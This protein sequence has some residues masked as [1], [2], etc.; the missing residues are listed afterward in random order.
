[1][2]VIFRVLLQM[3]VSPDHTA[4]FEAAWSQVAAGIAANPAN[5]GQALMRDCE[6]SRRYHVLSDWTDENAFRAF[7]RSDL[8]A[9]NRAELALYRE[10]V[11]MTTLYV[12]AQLPGHRNPTNGKAG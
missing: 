2:S 3:D 11:T 5:L 4:E 10:S 8:H 9:G 1:M 7:E 12:L 6:D